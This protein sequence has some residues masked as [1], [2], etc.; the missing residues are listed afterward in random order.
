LKTPS[1]FIFD[2]WRPLDGDRSRQTDYVGHWVFC[3]VTSQSGQSTSGTSTLRLEFTV[4]DPSSSEADD[5]SFSSHPN[6][7]R[8]FVRK[9]LRFHRVDMSDEEHKNRKVSIRIAFLDVEK[10]QDGY[11]CGYRALMYA[12]A[13]C[14]YTRHLQADKPHTSAFDCAYEVMTTIQ[15]LQTSQSSIYNFF[16]SLGVIE[17]IREDAVSASASEAQYLRAARSIVARYLPLKT[18]RSSQHRLRSMYE[19]N[20]SLSPEGA[21]SIKLQK[22]DLVR[23]AK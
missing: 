20:A 6:R 12:S 18:R 5:F 11:S 19:A 16:L 4:F 22:V 13:Y 14:I 3:V 23:L 7:G 17:Y 8:D 2:A 21:L 1:Y 15:Q 10:Q 9:L